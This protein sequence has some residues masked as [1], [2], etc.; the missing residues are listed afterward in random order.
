[1]INKK[2]KPDS[3]FLNPCYAE[4]HTSLNNGSEVMKL[5]IFALKLL[6]KSI[7]TGNGNLICLIHAL[8]HPDLTVFVFIS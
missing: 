5:E 7:A 2:N 3:F 6:F 1:V 8:S 4:Y